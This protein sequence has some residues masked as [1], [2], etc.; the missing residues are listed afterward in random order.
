M[1][2]S[3]I[4]SLD[5]QRQN[6]FSDLLKML[7][8][9]GYVGRQ[10]TATL[11]KICKEITFKS[12]IHMDERPAVFSNKMFTPAKQTQYTLLLVHICLF[13]GHFS[14]FMYDPNIVKNLAYLKLY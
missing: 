4:I 2:Q 13:Y 3:L 6:N 9:I 14:Q 1:I 11:T 7:I 10:I 5:L 8:P 12:R